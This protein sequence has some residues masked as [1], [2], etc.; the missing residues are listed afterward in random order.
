MYKSS[1]NS[2]L[3][4][5]SDYVTTTVKIRVP[6]PCPNRSHSSRFMSSMSSRSSNVD[7]VVKIAEIVSIA[8][9][10]IVVVPA[11]KELQL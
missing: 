11:S 5:A 8:Q 7:E 1:K 3:S 2:Y 9:I 4:V 10:V 6:S